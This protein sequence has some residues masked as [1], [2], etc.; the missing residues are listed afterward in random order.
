MNR[1][2]LSGTT[3]SPAPVSVA[4]SGSAA[5]AARSSVASQIAASL[6]V[7]SKPFSDFEQSGGHVQLWQVSDLNGSGAG[8]AVSGSALSLEGI[9]MT[10]DGLL[11]DFAALAQQGATVTGLIPPNGD[12]GHIISSDLGTSSV[13]DVEI[14]FH[15]G[16]P[17]IILRSVGADAAKGDTVE[18]RQAMLKSIRD[19]YSGLPKNLAEA[20]AR[21]TD[22]VQRYEPD[23]S[24]KMAVRQ[25]IDFSG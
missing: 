25:G 18:Q 14:D 4:S 21:N 24:G 1:I 8:P 3:N 10:S 23:G 17:P 20:L 6:G 13:V 9:P 22:G 12:M 19:L 7:A 16:R 11:P 5:P 2:G 15:D